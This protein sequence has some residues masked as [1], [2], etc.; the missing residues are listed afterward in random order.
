MSSKIFGI[1]NCNTM[2]KTINL[3]EKEGFSYEFVDY[4][5]Q[6]PS[7]ELL[8]KF[9]KKLDLDQ[10]VNRKGMTYRKL[11]EEEKAQTE[12]PKTAIP[13][14]QEKSSM[15]KRPI[16]EFPNGELLAGFDEE[17]ILAKGK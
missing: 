3:F 2:K 8:E 10:V 17:A 12:N 9:L 1:K 11:T 6:K 5:K 15:I 16:I 4:K 13:L 14:L 7:L